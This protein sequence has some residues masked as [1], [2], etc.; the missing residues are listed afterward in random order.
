MNGL[1]E[2]VIHQSFKDLGDGTLELACNLTQDFCPQTCK[3]VQY[4]DASTQK[5]YY[6]TRDRSRINDILPDTEPKHYSRASSDQYH[7][8]HKL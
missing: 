5:E 8:Y 3:L 6:S 1:K 4:S 7:L 2:F